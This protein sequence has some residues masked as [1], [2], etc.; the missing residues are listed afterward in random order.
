MRKIDR[1]RK[2]KERK[3]E[4]TNER[5]KERLKETGNILGT[6]A[7]AYF[8]TTYTNGRKS[9]IERSMIKYTF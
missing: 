9:F 6:N 4:R 7:L 8:A 2:T 3:N 5:T 1:E